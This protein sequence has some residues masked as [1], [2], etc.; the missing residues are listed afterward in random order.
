M[1]E[2]G[3]LPA[4]VRRLSASLK[5]LNETSMATSRPTR[6]YQLDFDSFVNRN[7]HRHRARFDVQ[8][9]DVERITRYLKNPVGTGI[10]RLSAKWI[11][12]SGISNDIWAELE[13]EILALSL[14]ALKMLKLC[15][16]LVSVAK[17]ATG[18]GS[19]SRCLVHL[20]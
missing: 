3:P 19:N 17:R 6:L 16:I 18:T 20:H 8:P 11:E 7:V 2:C 4:N 12:E 14:P 5:L 9:D 10:W 1:T 15:H 13:K